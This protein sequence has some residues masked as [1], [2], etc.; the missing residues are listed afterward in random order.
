MLTAVYIVYAVTLK[1]VRGFRKKDYFVAFILLFVA[2]AAVMAVVI[3]Q[4][5]FLI[6][7]LGKDAT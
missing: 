4:P 6:K 3:L 5:D 1:T 2:F 7:L